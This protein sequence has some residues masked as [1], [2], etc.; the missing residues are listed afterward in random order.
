MLEQARAAVALR[1]AGRAD[2]V[3]FSAEDATRSDPAFLAEVC[4]AAIA[5]RR[6][7]GQPAG[8][9][10][11]LPAGRVRRRSSPTVQALCPELDQV[12]LSVHCHDDLGLAVANTLAGRRAPARRR[13]SAP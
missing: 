2:E 9:R 5:R 4:R 3:E 13:S 6:D 10:R 8:H 12:V 7:D 11:L 1:A